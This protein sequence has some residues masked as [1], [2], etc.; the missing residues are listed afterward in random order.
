MKAINNI[1]STS[2]RKALEYDLNLTELDSA[3]QAI[4]AFISISGFES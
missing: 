3:S 2:F 4:I 1:E